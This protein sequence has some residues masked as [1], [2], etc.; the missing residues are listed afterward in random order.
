MSDPD[1]LRDAVA[2]IRREGHKAAAASAALDGVLVVLAVNLALAVGP[3]AVPTPDLLPA[4]GATV[5]AAAVGVAFACLDG[6][7]RA[8]WYSV[9]AFERA[10]PE[11]GA[12]LR[13]ARDAADDDHANAMA[14]RCYEDALDRLG[15]ASSHA[16]LDDRTLAL[17]TVLVFAVAVATIHVAVIDL[18]VDPLGD[19]GPAVADDGAG[20]GP[21]ASTPSRDE[22]Y[23]SSGSDVLGDPENVSQ[24]S[25][26]LGANVSGG[27][28]GTGGGNRAD[29]YR[30]SGLS[31]G[32]TVEAR[33]AG[34]DDPAAVEDADL[35]RDYT[36]RVNG[37]ESE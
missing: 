13:S 14:R 33:R 36:L 5:G 3:V 2:E 20:D 34:Y 35:I 23:L 17:R 26:A 29:G 15:D 37:T 32:G 18:S 21:D 30:D 8:R 28:G 11:L 1:S 9:A 31:A 22:S 10:N 19:A 12:A 7:L 16:L 25:E 24:G 4:D 27:P 6:W